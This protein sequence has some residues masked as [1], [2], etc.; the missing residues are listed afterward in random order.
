MSEDGVLI[1]KKEIRALKEQVK[2]AE[3]EVVKVRMENDKLKEKT[4]MENTKMKQEIEKLRSAAAVELRRMEKLENMNS[5][6]SIRLS[7]LFGSIT[8]SRILNS[9]LLRIPH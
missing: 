8:M 6:V 1:L 7:T 4:T 5:K 3:S 9:L 2:T